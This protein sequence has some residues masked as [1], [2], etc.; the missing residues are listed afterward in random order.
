MEKFL[1]LDGLEYVCGR[2][3]SDL[4]G[5]QDVLT[6]QPGQ[7]VGFDSTGAAMARNGWGNPN[8]LDN[9]YFVDPINQRVRGEY[10]GTGYMIDRWF[11]AATSR[12][13]F[14]LTLTDNGIL[15]DCTNDT[16]RCFFQQKVEREIQ[17]SNYY[18]LSLLYR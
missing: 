14:K 13:R 2:L 3:R 11:Q 4:S 6:G 8:L 17:L 1:N 5:K 7:V 18:T 12:P 16:P 10:I 15:L 9:W